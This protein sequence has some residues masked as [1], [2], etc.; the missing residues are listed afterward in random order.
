M[1]NQSKDATRILINLENCFWRWYILIEGGKKEFVSQRVPQKAWEIRIRIWNS[2]AGIPSP[3]LTLFS[4]MFPKAHLTSHSRMSG[5][6]W[7]ITPLWLSGSRRSSL[8]SSV[9]SYHL[10]LKY[11]ASV[12]SLPFLS[13]I[14][15]IFTW[16]VPLVSLIF[17]EEISSLSLLLF[18]SVS[19]FVL[20]Y[21]I[22]RLSYLSLVFFG[23]LHSVGC[24]FPSLL[25]FF[26]S[27][28]STLHP[29]HPHPP[30]V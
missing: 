30:K 10:F 22:R 17:L 11:S 14:V 8:Y 7:V 23:I 19:F 27:H 1:N 13:F 4:V 20:P 18:S 21:K 6:R 5:S 25:P 29:P 3:P 15:P 24:L 2:S 28:Y 12:R 16:N 26:L 9:S